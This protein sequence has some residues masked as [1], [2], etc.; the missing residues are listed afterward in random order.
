MNIFKGAVN[1]EHHA[2]KCSNCGLVFDHNP[3]VCKTEYEYE[4][5][6]NCPACGTEE[7]HVYS[8][9]EESRCRHSGNETRFYNKGEHPVEE[10]VPMSP[11]MRERMRMSVFLKLMAL[12]EKEAA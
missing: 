8:G 6:H 11:Q 7:T 1:F 5:A 12:M 2:H 9:D 4:Q 3:S 10:D